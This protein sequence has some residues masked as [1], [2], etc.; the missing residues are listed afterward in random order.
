MFS[1]YRDDEIVMGFPLED[2][3]GLTEST[4]EKEIIS[5][6]CGCI[7]DDI[8]ANA[9]EAIEKNRIQQRH[10]PVLRSLRE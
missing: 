6:L 1:G 2:F 7:M 9:V 4:E 5:A 8:P 3:I 10:R